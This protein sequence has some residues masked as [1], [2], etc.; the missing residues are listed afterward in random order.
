IVGPMQHG[1]TLSTTAVE[2]ARLAAVAYLRHVPGNR[3]PSSD[4]TR[5]VLRSSPHVVAAVPLE[6]AARVL[7]TNP[8]LAPPLTSRLGGV[9]AEVVETG[10]VPLRAQLRA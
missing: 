10:V 8:S 2:V 7:R 1:L 4:L 3:A 6:P 9:D 5:I